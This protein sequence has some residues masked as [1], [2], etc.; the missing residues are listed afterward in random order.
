V[1]RDF[2]DYVEKSNAARTVDELFAVF[3]AAVKRHGLDRALFCIATEHRDIAQKPGAAVICN[4]PGDWMKYYFEQGFD[5][6]DPVMIYGLTQQGSYTWGD[7]PERMKL[8]KKQ[9]ECLDL[10]AE[11]GLNNGICT[12][13]R[14]PNN[15]LAGISL[16]STEKIDAFD[17]K[18]DLITAYSNHFYTAWKRMHLKTADGGVVQEPNVSLTPVQKEILTWAAKGKTDSDISAIMNVSGHTVDWHMRNI[19]RKLDARGR[20]LAV[21]KAF[22][23][24]LI[25]P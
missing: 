6:I 5:K 4:Y 16:A 15:Q 19:F 2:E 3:L 23:Y 20:I 11:A 22:S 10:G 18:I 9:K 14:G 12:P 21:V 13:L 24:G 25:N 7:I 8:K 17:G 1:I